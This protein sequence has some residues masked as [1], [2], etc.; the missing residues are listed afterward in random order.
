MPDPF[1]FNATIMIS[2]T[3]ENRRE[4]ISPFLLLEL[5]VAQLIF[6]QTCP[7]KFIHVLTTIKRRRWQPTR[8]Q[9]EESV[10]IDVATTFI[11]L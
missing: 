10:S 9:L 2:K 11:K 1:F 4:K 3:E 8:Q 5:G 7:F 6:P